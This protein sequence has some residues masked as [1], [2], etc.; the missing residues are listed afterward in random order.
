MRFLHCVLHNVT[1]AN[2]ALNNRTMPFLSLRTAAQL[3]NCNLILKIY[4]SENKQDRGSL[5]SSLT[6][7]VENKVDTCTLINV[8]TLNQNRAPDRL[9]YQSALV[10]FF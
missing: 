6:L 7:F 10:W 1:Y 3:R 2:K 9:F 5:V 4:K 8:E